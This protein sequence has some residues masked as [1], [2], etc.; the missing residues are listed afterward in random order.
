MA[1]KCLK[2][3]VQT[4]F[5]LVGLN[6]WYKSTIIV[7]RGRTIVGDESSKVV[8]P[9]VVLVHIRTLE[10][11]FSSTDRLHVIETR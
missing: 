4:G 10:Y 5:S 9:V 2:L 6:F 11:D 3:K 7:L 8:L 1:L